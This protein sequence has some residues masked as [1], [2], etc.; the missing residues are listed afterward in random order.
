MDRGNTHL[1]RHVPLILTIMVSEYVL[2]TSLLKVNNSLVI[3]MFSK[4]IFL[5]LFCSSW[6]WG[7][8]HPLG[9]FHMLFCERLSQKGISTLNLVA[10]AKHGG[11]HTILNNFKNHKN[12]L[13]IIYNN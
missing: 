4:S 13:I 8:C 9:Q 12:V 5:F 6:R 3:I 10:T 7:S 1:A 11:S 2:L